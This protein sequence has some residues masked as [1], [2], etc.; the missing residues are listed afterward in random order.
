MASNKPVSR[1]VLP[2]QTSRACLGRMRSF[3]YQLILACAT[4]G[5]A[6]A[7]GGADAN[8]PPLRPIDA[9]AVQRT[10]ERLA[11]EMLVPGA[12][13]ILRTPNGEFTAR[14]G[15]TS[16]QGTVPTGFDQHVRVGSNTK[17][18]IGTVI[19]QQIQERRLALNDPVSKYRPDVPNGDNITIEHL[20]SM[21][22]GL[23]NYTTTLELNRTLDERPAKAWTPDELLALGYQHKPYFTPPGASFAYSNTNTVL[24]GLIAEQREGGKP[25]AAIMRERLF[26]PL[27]LKNTLLPDIRSNAIPEPFARGYMY[28]NNVL[29]MG[30]PPALPNDMQ[31]AARA[32]TL[33]PGDQTDANPSW[34]WAAGAGISTANDLVAWVEALVDGKLLN[35]DLQARRLASVLPIDPSNPNTASYGWAIAKFGNLFGHTGELPGYNSFMGRDPRNRVTLVVWANLAPTVDGRDP[36]TTIARELIGLLYT[37]AR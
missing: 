26:A 2:I 16:Y 3:A 34:G 25:L 30:T 5:L 22:S 31:V 23:Y 10:V 4:A 17:T 12:V 1:S 15:V 9:A 18:W 27:G 37:P 32:G 21:R 7:S 14:Y 28:G 35:A 6:V 33:A 19:L 8:E 11:K 24:L 13:V 29:T 36:A 20:L